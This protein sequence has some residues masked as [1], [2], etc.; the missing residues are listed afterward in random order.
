MGTLGALKRRWSLNIISR[1][2]CNGDKPNKFQ[3]NCEARYYLYF[4]YKNL[5]NP[6]LRQFQI[7]ALKTSPLKG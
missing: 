5:G 2:N 4:M 1:L 6:V 7:Q 3:K